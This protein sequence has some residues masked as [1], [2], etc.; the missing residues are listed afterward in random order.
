[1]Y[2]GKRKALAAAIA[3]RDQ[4]IARNPPMTLKAFCSVI[5]RNNRSGISGVC[6]YASRDPRQDGTLRWY[7]IATWSPE[8][9]KTKQIKFSVNKYGEKGAFQRAV[10]ARKKALAQ[11]K[12]HFSRATKNG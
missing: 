10:Q 5:K 3:Y 8:P 12:G 1:V 6:R 4:I 2:G 11:L 7:W 9:H